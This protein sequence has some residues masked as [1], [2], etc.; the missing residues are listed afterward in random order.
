MA[1]QPSKS[2]NWT[3]TEILQICTPQNNNP[4]LFRLKWEREKIYALVTW[5]YKDIKNGEE[6]ML[7]EKMSSVDNLI[8]QW[9]KRNLTWIGKITIIQS[10]RL[11][12]I[13]FAI[14]RFPTPKDFVNGLIV[15]LYGFIWDSK[16]A[17]VKNNVLTNDYCDG[18]LKMIDLKQY[19]KTQKI[20]WLKKLLL[21]METLPYIY[22]YQFRSIP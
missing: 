18:G 17:R 20:M 22:S 13:N 8:K 3:K 21:N 14:C 6:F 2:V 12:K 1:I 5:F 7:S 9:M 19:V 15:D 4:S 16:P 10:L 11:S